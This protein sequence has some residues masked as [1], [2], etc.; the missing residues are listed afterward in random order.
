MTACCRRYSPTAPSAT[1]AVATMRRWTASRSI[2]CT[3]SRARTTHWAPTSQIGR[4]PHK[5]LTF[6]GELPNGRGSRLDGKMGA[7]LSL[8]ARVHSVPADHLVCFLPG[9]MA[10]G[11]TGGLLE[12]A[13]RNKMTPRDIE[14]LKLA[15][16]I[17]YA[18]YQV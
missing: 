3:A 11:A 10:L 8:R 2:W 4:T 7:S 15:E 5:N 1:S 14:D 17:A 18:C 6:V 13:V 16:E 12:S 9:T